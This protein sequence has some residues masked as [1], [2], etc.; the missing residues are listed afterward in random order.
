MKSIPFNRSYQESAGF[1][2]SLGLDEGG[3][4]L[5]TAI[6][7]VSQSISES[8]GGGKS[9]MTPSCTASLE[10]VALLL[11]L[12]EG[13]EIIMPSFTFVST[14]NAFSHIESLPKN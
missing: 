13:D 4:C 5:K 2:G 11:D 3:G 9:L 1:Q 6:K 12:K 10:M 8:I 7:L 14:A